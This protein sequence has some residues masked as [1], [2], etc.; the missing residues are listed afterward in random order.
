MNNF[1]FLP[2]D[3]NNLIN[4]FADEIKLKQIEIKTRLILLMDIHIAKCNRWKGH[5]LLHIDELDV[6]THF[7]IPHKSDK[8]E[9]KHIIYSRYA[10]KFMDGD[11]IISMRG[12]YD[13]YPLKKN[14]VLLPNII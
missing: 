2:N 3:I 14:G 8:Y 13:D 10:N 12:Y 6:L 11:K 9:H 5:K 7:L 1:K 4:E